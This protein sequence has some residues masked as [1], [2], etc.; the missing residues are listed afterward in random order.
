MERRRFFQA[1]AAVGGLA[2]IA[3]LRAAAADRTIRVAEAI[4]MAGRQR[5]LSQRAAKAWLMQ[6]M[7]V[8]PERASTWLAASVTL[9][10]RQMSELRSLQPNADIA[11]L[12]VE[13]AA[14]WQGY[15]A[16]LAQPATHAS[17]MEVYRRSD[18]VLAAAHATTQAYE[19]LAST[20]VGRLINVSGRQRMLSQ[21]MAKDVCFARYGVETEA[22]MA[23]L[24]QAREEFVTALALLKAAPE[25]TP[26][27]RDELALAD[28]QWF[29]FQ[30]AL[31][32]SEA[33]SG[34]KDIGTTSERILE[35][36]N[37]V[38]GLYEQR[39]GAASQG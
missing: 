36:L 2:A 16:V 25:N 39:F 20:S 5:M 32:R 19:R 23:A 12:L 3:P 13:E 4:N 33:S 14:A 31:G 38:V 10:E 8:L 7:G 30:D 9:F 24:A 15:R 28:Q 22:S 17:A 11:R 1:L 6:A 18:A 34:L 26:R 29:F 35:Q 37:L 21:R 27:I